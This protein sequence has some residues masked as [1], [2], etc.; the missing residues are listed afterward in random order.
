MPRDSAS[1]AGDNGETSGAAIEYDGSEDPENPAGDEIP[2]VEKNGKVKSSK[3]SK[4]Q[5][6]ATKESDREV[7]EDDLELQPD[8][9]DELIKGAAKPSAE[10]QEGETVVKDTVGDT[11][12]SG[13][14]N[15]PAAKPTGRSVAVSVTGRIS[16]TGRSPR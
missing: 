2:E 15:S 12:S 14:K 9:G 5:G 1:Y 8:K 7:E 13:T 11:P 6:G 4:E 3:G 10:Q 16:A